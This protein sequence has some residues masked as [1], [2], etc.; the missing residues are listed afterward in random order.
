[1]KIDYG[2]GKTKYGPGVLI[3]L[4]AEELA[5][6]ITSWLVANDVHIQGP[7][8]IRVWSDDNAYLEAGQVYVDPNGQVKQG[9]RL[10]SGR[11]E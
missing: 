3:D 4:T 11:G 9:D 7:R 1:M 6:A 8:T 5:T 2:T 10:W